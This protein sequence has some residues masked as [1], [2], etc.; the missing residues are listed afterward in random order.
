MRLLMMKHWRR[1]ALL[2]LAL[3]GKSTCR[4][5]ISPLSRL[6]PNLTSYTSF[7]S[8]LRCQFLFLQRPLSS[9]NISFIFL[10]YVPCLFFQKARLT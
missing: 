8:V 9:L 1:P 10:K 5:R 6:Q 2:I 3:R 7:S 4:Q